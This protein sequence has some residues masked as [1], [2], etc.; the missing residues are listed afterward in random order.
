MNTSTSITIDQ[1]NSI[2]KLYADGISVESA[3]KQLQH[4]TASFYALVNDNSDCEK[5][6][7]RVQLCRC[8]K[9]A[10]EIIDI[11]DDRSDDPRSRAVRI[12][13]RKWTL[14]HMLPKKYGDKIDVTTLG[15]K[16]TG[17]CFTV[18][19]PEQAPDGN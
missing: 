19:K 6:Y 4:S 2:L 17:V 3:C 18:V 12:D 14:A 11:A 10:D 1:F 16:V 13:A 7:T 15:E 9:Q 5:S 8:R